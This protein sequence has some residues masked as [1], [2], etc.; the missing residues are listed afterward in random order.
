MLKKYAIYIKLLLF[1]CIINSIYI[2]PV[3]TNDRPKYE[4][5]DRCKDE[6]AFFRSLKYWTLV[7]FMSAPL[8]YDIELHKKD[9][10]LMIFSCNHANGM[11]DDANIAMIC[12][13]KAACVGGVEMIIQ[14]LL[15]HACDRVIAGVGGGA[16]LF[17]TLSEQPT[18]IVHSV[19]GT[20]HTLDE[21]MQNALH[22]MQPISRLIYSIA[23]HE[24]RVL[25]MINGISISVFTLHAIKMIMQC[26]A[27]FQCYIKR[28]TSLSMHT[29]ETQK[30]AYIRF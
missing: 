30:N 11:C 8:L 28:Y 6:E 27:Y 7:T 16:W 5:Y 15:H 23:I 17:C 9:A 18:C 4:I 21:T 3:H 2:C 13:M 25:V 24:P 12:F 26:I 29:E 20:Q 22:K 1:I 10:G 19:C 14:M